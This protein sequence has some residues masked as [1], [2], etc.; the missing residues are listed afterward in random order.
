MAKTKPKQ[1]ESVVR[2]AID[3]IKLAEKPQTFEKHQLTVA[4]ID[5]EMDKYGWCK[6]N[7]V[8]IARMILRELVIARLERRK[9]G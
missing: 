6:N 9:N 7:L 2:E 1:D 3:T 4:E 5:A 8:D